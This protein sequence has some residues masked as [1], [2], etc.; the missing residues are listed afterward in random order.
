MTS[1]APQVVSKNNHYQ[2]YHFTMKDARPFSNE[3]LVATPLTGGAAKVAEL[4]QRI[5][6]GSAT[7]KETL[8]DLPP[9]FAKSVREQ[10]IPKTETSSTRIEGSPSSPEAS[11]IDLNFS[12]RSMADDVMPP[13]YRGITDPEALDIMW[14]VPIYVDPEKTKSELARKQRAMDSLKAS[15]RHEI[16]NIAEAR[17]IVHLDSIRAQLEHIDE[18]TAPTEPVA[19]EAE[20]APAPHE[21][22][23]TTP[24]LESLIA[25]ATQGKSEAV[26]NLYAGWMKDPTNPA[27]RKLLARALFQDAY[28]RYRLADY[29]IDE[30]EENTWEDALRNPRVPINNKKPEWQYRGEFPKG[31]ES[32]ITRGSLNVH[33]TPQLIEGLDGLIASGKVRM[34]YKFGM[35]GSTAAP[36]SRHDSVSMYF[37]E[38]PTEEIIKAISH[39]AA[40]FVRGDSLL[41][42]K[43]ADGFYISEVG[44][45]DSDHVDQLIEDSSHIDAAL[46]DAIREYASPRPGQGTRLKLSEAQYYAVKDVSRVFG[47]DFSYNTDTGFSVGTH[48]PQSSFTTNTSVLGQS[49][50]PKA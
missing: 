40:P 5:N 19:S 46:A 24:T 11:T 31:N 48:T 35:P 47:T 15:E 10:L 30:H 23:S 25:T 8:R 33:V 34:N 29:P 14:T 50:A 45:I 20:K 26:K 39:V 37:L 9:G 17:E 42:T 44:N 1:I 28:N 16:S 32:T 21:A 6:S 49:T 2:W 22:I 3:T 13:Q 38:E 4:A 7:E 18:P 43:V 27:N 36:T 41:G 12:F